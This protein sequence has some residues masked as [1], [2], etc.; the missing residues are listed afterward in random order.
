MTTT[1]AESLTIV[2]IERLTSTLHNT[3]FVTTGAT[4]LQLTN[5]SYEKL[6]GVHRGATRLHALSSLLTEVEGTMHM[7]YMSVPGPMNEERE[8]DSGIPTEGAQVR[9]QARDHA[10][11]KEKKRKHGSDD[12]G[13]AEEE[14]SDAESKKVR[15]KKQIGDREE[16]VAPADPATSKLTGKAE[17]AA[18]TEHTLSSGRA[19]KDALIGVAPVKELRS[20]RQMSVVSEVGRKTRGKGPTRA[21]PNKK[22]GGRKGGK[23][24]DAIKEAGEEEDE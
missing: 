18:D 5:G 15:R 8:N 10:K 7:V 9:G 23:E 14:D 1:Q 16:G 20:G 12:E 6:Y 22:A 19:A 11:E 4:I 24:M 17:A 13:I 2:H 21:T 3:S